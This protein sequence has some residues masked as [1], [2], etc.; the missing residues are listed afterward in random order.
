MI[1]EAGERVALVTGAGRRVGRVIAA[2]LAHSGY[3]MA[4]HAHHS[5]AAAQE[6]V[7][8]LE[9]EGH[10]ALAVRGDLGD[11]KSLYEMVDRVHAHF[12]RIDALVNSAAIWQPGR[13]EE[14]TAA[15]VRRHFDLNALGTFLCCQRVGL[16]MVD[17]V[18]GGGIVNIGDWAVCRPYRGYSAYFPSKGAVPTMTRMFAV[19]LGRR[20]PNVRVN[21]VLP[22]PVMLPKDL[23]QAQ[24]QAAIDATLVRREGRPEHVA[25]A[26]QFLLENDFVTGVS[27]PVDGG[28]TAYAPDADQPTS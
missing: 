5:F 16:I 19:E 18:S 2:A 1:R 10:A 28:R 22:G 4:V 11:E 27:L 23:P 15:D 21:A 3:R 25:H 7:G 12:H 20:N 14:V 8:D 24:R 9:A 26:V 17:Q 13:L 6:L